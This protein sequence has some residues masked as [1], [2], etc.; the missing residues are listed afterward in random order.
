MGL[1]WKQKP[2]HQGPG[3]STTQV[4]NRVHA[5]AL[6]EKEGLEA[7]MPQDT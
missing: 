4:E 1:V 2:E 3:K 6:K 5:A 7:R